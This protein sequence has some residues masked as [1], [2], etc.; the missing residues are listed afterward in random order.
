MVIQMDNRRFYPIR[1]AKIDEWEDAM[2]LAWRTFMKYEAP[3][4][5]KR[6]SESFLE[7]ISDNGLYKMFCIGQYKLFIA[8][9]NDKIVGLISIRS[10]NHISLLFVDGAYHKRGIGRSLINYAAM[11]VRE[12]TK[13]TTITVAAA[14]Y[15]IEFYHRLGFKDTGPQGISDGMIY[16]PMEL[17]I[18]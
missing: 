12:E 4:Y 7:F 14:P 15:A 16:V 9:D 5:P 11:Y 6:G 17:N 3:D 2:S 18:Q 1:Q 13:L 8:T 10:R